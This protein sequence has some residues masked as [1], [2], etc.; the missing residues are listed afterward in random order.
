MKYGAPGEPIELSLGIDAEVQV[1]RKDLKAKDRKGGFLSCEQSMERAYRITLESHATA[2]VAVEVR[3][4]IPVSKVEEVEVK[5]KKGGTT[6][7]YQ[8]DA[9]RGFVSWTVTPAPAGRASVDLA[10]EIRLPKDW[11]V[12][13]R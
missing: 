13:G 8:L 4:S 2:P 6:P 11:K 10:Y 12:R 7:G 1:S 9:H 5:L 3:D